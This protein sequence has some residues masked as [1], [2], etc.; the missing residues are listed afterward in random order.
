MAPRIR[1]AT[2]ADA[3]AVSD[4]YAPYVTDD[5]ASFESTPPTAAEM[6]NRITDTLVAHPWLVCDVSEPPN[7]A[8]TEDESGDD[9]ILG[10]AYAGPH[11][12]RDAYRWSVDVS[13]YVRG[14]SHRAG[15]ATG[16]YESMLAILERQGFRTAYAGITLPNPAS[17][18]FHAAMGFEP[19]GTYE[20]VGY[21]NG[22]WHD[23][24]WYARPFGDYPVAPDEPVTLA[25]VRKQGDWPDVLGAGDASIS[26]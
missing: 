5:V 11:R 3:P 10:Y 9:A 20:R 19:V 23:V 22:G 17:E 13:V 25:E 24:G 18:G 6:R 26:H 2:P 1:L 16:L 12:S 8:D 14:E 4:V 15:V 21:K 7:E